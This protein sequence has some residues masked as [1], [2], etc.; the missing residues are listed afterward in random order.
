MILHRLAG[1]TMHIGI[2]CWAMAGQYPVSHP[3]KIGVGGCRT[4]KTTKIT[5]KCSCLCED[6]T[7]I[8]KASIMVFSAEALHI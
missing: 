5:A 7:K 3:G 1:G 8:S 4:N 6:M 2:Y